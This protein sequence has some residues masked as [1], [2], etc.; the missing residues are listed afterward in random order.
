MGSL[1]N[2][3]TPAA[4]Q[5]AIWRTTTLLPSPSKPVQMSRSL[6]SSRPGITQ[7]LGGSTMEM[8]SYRSGARSG[9]YSSPGM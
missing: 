8:N 1:V 9:L 3:W 7:S 5:T 2:G 4:A 6:R